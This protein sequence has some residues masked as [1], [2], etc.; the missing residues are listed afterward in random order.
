M[1]SSCHHQ[2]PNTDTQTIPISF[3]K[4]KNRIC[5]TLALALHCSVLQAAL[6]D[7]RMLEAAR[8]HRDGGRLCSTAARPGEWGAK[9]GMKGHTKRKPPKTRSGKENQIF[10]SSAGPH[11]T[12]MTQI[13]AKLH[14]N[15]INL[16]LTLRGAKGLNRSFK[17]KLNV[18]FKQLSAGVGRDFV[19][20]GNRYPLLLTTVLSG[21]CSTWSL[22]E[23]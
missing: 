2:K 13:I 16:S 3:R 14:R 9:G 12:V 23:Q 11:A 6:A 18:I 10:H 4:Y 22:R 20:W 15:G 5:W 1:A 21:G 17:F 8:T 7:L 19:Q